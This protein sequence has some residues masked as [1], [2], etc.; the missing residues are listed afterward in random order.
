MEPRELANSICETLRSN[1]HDALLAGGRLCP[2]HFVR[3]APPADYD[4]AN[5]RNSRPG[6]GPCFPEQRGGRGT[7][8]AF[9]RCISGRYAG[10]SGD[11]PALMLA[12]PIGPPSG[13]RGVRAQSEGRRAAPRF[14][15]LTG[16]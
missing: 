5:G 6:H 1:G 14:S 12:T 4:V 2:R 13:R 10:G 16:C 15:R 3:G 7:V 9:N 8:L 11:I